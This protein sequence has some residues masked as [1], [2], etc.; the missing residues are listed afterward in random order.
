LNECEAGGSEPHRSCIENRDMARVA[1]AIQLEGTMWL[2]R[3]VEGIEVKLKCMQFVC[4][5]ISWK[6]NRFSLQ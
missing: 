5:F 4:V 3:V 1:G 6:L 2:R